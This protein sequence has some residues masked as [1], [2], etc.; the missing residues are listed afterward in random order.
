MTTL[1]WFFTVG[2]IV[3]ILCMLFFFLFLFLTFGSG[4]KVRSLKRVRTKNKKKRKRL[5]LKKRQMIQRKK[6]QRN[7]ALLFFVFSLLFAAGAVY[8]AYYQTMNLTTE[9]SDSIIQGYYLLSDFSSQLEKAGESS[10]TEEK[11][12]GNLRYLSS[13]LSSYGVKKA[14]YLNTEEGQL[15]LNR[16]YG[17]M[18]E[19]GMNATN[20][21]SKIYGNPELVKEYQADIDKITE[22]QKKVFEMYKV[23]ENSLELKK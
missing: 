7:S 11:T 14:S 8:S 12:L 20:N 9:D 16:Y 22:N 15:L 5:L 3:S 23:D 2:M 21:L 6:N 4:A 19:I 17:S 18:K 10:E 1:D 13:S